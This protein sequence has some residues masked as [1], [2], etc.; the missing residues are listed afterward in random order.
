ITEAINAE[1]FN[2]FVIIT[3]N[4][5]ASWANGFR[6][7]WEWLLGRTNVRSHNQRISSE[8]GSRN[9][10]N[11]MEA[12][13]GA[14]SFDLGPQMTASV[15]RSAD[16][17]TVFMGHNDVCQD[18][19]SNIP[20]DAEF[21]ANVRAGFDALRAGLPNG[22]TVYTLGIV[23]IYKLWQL[24]PQL[25]GLLGVSCEVVW[26]TTLIGAFPCGTM[27]N[28]LNSEADRQY[29]RSRNVA[30][31]QILEDLV[32]E[33][34]TTDPHHHWRFSDVAFQADFVPSEV[35]PFDCFHP[36]AEGQKRLA[37][38]SWQAGPFGN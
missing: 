22:A 25:S 16:Y 37:R 10:K 36:S 24:G 12:L 6:G 27:L 35:S 23:D 8:F 33:F 26:A 3:P 7:F 17:V 30:F 29:T 18:S 9:R 21:E 28:P 5:W 20:T 4:H 15:S 13:S 2:P 19:F 34:E 32:M 11:F 38:D 1:E 31:N 14:D